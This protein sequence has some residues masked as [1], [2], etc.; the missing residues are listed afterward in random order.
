MQKDCP[1]K[2]RR[3]GSLVRAP[4]PRDLGI[5]PVQSFA[6]TPLDGPSRFIMGK[7]W[8]GPPISTIH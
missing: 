7:D 5:T 4:F 8:L 6:F 1:F 2:W 3:D